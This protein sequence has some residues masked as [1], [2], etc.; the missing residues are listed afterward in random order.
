MPQLRRFPGKTG[1]N[2]QRVYSRVTRRPLHQQNGAVQ[3]STDQYRATWHHHSFHHLVFITCLRFALAVCPSQSM[4]PCHHYRLSTKTSHDD[5]L[6]T[7]VASCRA[8]PGANAT[9]LAI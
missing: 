8:T 4:G 7:R 5:K 2:E 6:W 1:F 3:S 9:R